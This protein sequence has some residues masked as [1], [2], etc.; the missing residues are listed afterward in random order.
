MTTKDLVNQK[1]TSLAAQLGTLMLQQSDLAD[2]ITLLKSQIAALNAL[3]P[4]L[5][6]MEASLKLNETQK[7]ENNA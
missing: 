6:K 7:E 4:D 5:Q 2:K 1:Y 3:V